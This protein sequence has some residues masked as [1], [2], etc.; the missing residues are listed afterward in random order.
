[1]KTTEADGLFPRIEAHVRRFRTSPTIP[2]LELEILD[3]W[4]R[5]GTFE[6]LQEQNRGGPEVLVRRRAAT[7]NRIGSESTLRSGR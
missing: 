4:E 7:A 2:A 5:E 3:L 6:R 1:M